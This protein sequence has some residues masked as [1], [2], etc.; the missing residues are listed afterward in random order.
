MELV[1]LRETPEFIGNVGKHQ[2]PAGNI[3]NQMAVDVFRS[4]KESLTLH[5]HF[6]TEL[7]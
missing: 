5:S 6:K 1:K 3:E 4:L 2:L 7:R